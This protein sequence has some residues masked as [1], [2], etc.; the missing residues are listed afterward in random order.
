M[1]HD[2]LDGLW[3][4]RVFNPHPLGPDLDAYY[5]PFDELLGNRAT[6][7]R[8]VTAAAGGGRVAVVGPTGSGKSSLLIRIFGPLSPDFAALRISTG[9]EAEQTLTDPKA[10]AQHVCRALA[11]QAT[12]AAH[13]SVEQR[14]EVL[15]A[16]SDRTHKPARERSIKGNLGFPV[17][18]LQGSLGVDLKQSVENIDQDRSASE[19]IAGLVGII[20]KIQTAEPQAVL[21]LDDTDRWLTVETGAP[22]STLVNGFFS[23]VFRMIADL[24]IGLAVAVHEAYLAFPGYQEAARNFIDTAIQ[25]PTLPS[26]SGLAPVLQQRLDAHET[27]MSVDAL[28]SNDA[29]DLLMRSYRLHRSLRTIILAVQTSLG[30]AIDAGVNRISEAHVRAALLDYTPASL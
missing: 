11:R 4:D 24:P 20:Q 17:W 18:L 14:D 10:F 12:D 28:L 26:R 2:H 29:L 8:L 6:E 3:R 9:F 21:L 5:V 22:R 16:T 23:R 1:S 7:D 30:I 19:I 27:G 25:L 15:R 13:M